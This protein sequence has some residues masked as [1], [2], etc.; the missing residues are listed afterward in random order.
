MKHNIESI[1]AGAFFLTVGLT[2]GGFQTNDLPPAEAHE[3]SVAVLEAMLAPEETIS[4]LELLLLEGT[5]DNGAKLTPEQ[6]KH[7]LYTVG[8]RDEALRQAWA[9]A[10]KE[11]TG[12]PMAH[13][14]N[15]K[16]GDNS[17][18]LFQINM[19]GSMGP[20]RLKQYGLESNEDLFDPMTNARI[21]YEMSN[22]GKNWKPWH[23]IG[24]STLKWMQEYPTN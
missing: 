13:N 4:D 1:F 20:D 23:G 24:N 9:V 12:R 6:L 16:T 3:D 2:V 8:F 14:D 15:P 22:G 10:M 21:A 17:Y 18:G 11:S 19:I 7:V 5:Y